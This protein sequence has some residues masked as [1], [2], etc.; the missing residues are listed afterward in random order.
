M[1]DVKFS[2]NEDTHHCDAV[3]EGKWIVFTCSQCLDYRRKMHQETGE[4]IT[5]ST[6]NPEIL[7][8]GFYVQPRLQ[9]FDASLS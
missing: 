4:M 7:H 8:Q 2:T 3:L 9:N 5:E 6:G 1:L